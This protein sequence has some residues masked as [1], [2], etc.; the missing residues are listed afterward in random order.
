MVTKEI[1]GVGNGYGYKILVDSKLI[2]M[3][4]HKPAI[5]GVQDMTLGEADKIGSLVVAKMNN[6][7]SPSVTVQQISDLLNGT[8]TIDQIIVEEKLG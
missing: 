4:P 8:K 2:I 6:N 5:S 7:L 1:Y 3:Q